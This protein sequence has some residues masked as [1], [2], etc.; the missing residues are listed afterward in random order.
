MV[1]Y[2]YNWLIDWLIKK[3]DSSITI[4]SYEM[5]WYA[6]TCLFAWCPHIFNVE[7]SRGLAISNHWHQRLYI[8]QIS[9]I[10]TILQSKL[11]IYWV[12]RIEAMVHP[13]LPKVTA[14]LEE[15]SN[16]SLDYFPGSILQGIQAIHVGK[17]IIECKL[18]IEDRVLVNSFTH[19]CIFLSSEDYIKPCE[20]Q[21]YTYKP[22]ELYFQS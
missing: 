3:I 13:A 1:F 11:H 10:K 2:G 12:T 4:F 9:K 6:R 17:G 8:S 15:L 21:S 19:R 5:N 22:V 20:M 18:I 16:A 7:I 14:Y